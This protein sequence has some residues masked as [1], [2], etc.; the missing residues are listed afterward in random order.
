MRDKN[1]TLTFAPYYLSFEQFLLKTYFKDD[2]AEN[3]LEMNC[4]K[5]KSDE[6][7]YESRLQELLKDNAIY[8][9]KSR[10][11]FIK[12]FIDACNCYS[13]VVCDYRVNKKNAKIQR[14]LYNRFEYLE[15]FLVPQNINDTKADKSLIT[16]DAFRSEDE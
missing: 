15:Q 2:Y 4:I 1:I 12:C 7:F 16:I 3:Y 13:N 6:V 14:Y 8:Y 10:E 5:Y 9:N 11:D